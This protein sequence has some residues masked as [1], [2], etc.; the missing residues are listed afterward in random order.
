MQEKNKHT[1]DHDAF[2]QWAKQQL[3]NHQLPVDDEIWKG[4]EKK[5][6]PAPKRSV[7]FWYWLAG[8]VAAVVALMLLLRP[9]YHSS[10]RDINTQTI[11]SQ[12]GAN[13]QVVTSEQ[14]PVDISVRPQVVEKDHPATGVKSNNS[15]R[16]SN[17]NIFIARNSETVKTKQ[18]E[19]FGGMT[20]ENFVS[21]MQ[22]SGNEKEKKERTVSEEHP[23]TTKAGD[24]GKNKNDNS[25]ANVSKQQITSLPDLSDYPEE[26][27]V[28]TVKNKKNE[29]W[30]LAASLGAGSG[31]SSNGSGLFFETGG[32]MSDAALVNSTSVKTEYTADIKD[33]D[34]F[35]EVQHLPPVSFGLM[36]ELP[37]NRSWSLESG[38]VYTYLESRL[39]RTTNPTATGHLKLHYLGLPLYLKAKLWHDTS[40]SIY[41]SAGPMMEKGLKSIYS[42]DI[43]YTW[44]ITHTDVHSRIEGLQW[45]LNTGLGVNYKLQ[46]DLSVF[47][48]PKLTY[49]LD[50]NQP[51][52]A[53]TEQPL[54]IGLNGG[55]RIEL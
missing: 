7:P 12:K 29:H 14:N 36:A 18:T 8:G 46:K 15:A 17:K 27:A 32:L 19:E 23:V 55:L 48:E 1:N 2:S 3:E 22:T 10:G 41:L 50:N 54:V 6:A 24:E 35:N 53:R 13:K 39:K 47:F 45:S 42:Q 28:E 51:M 33:A 34:Y 44:S 4:I 37:L 25:K 38:F 11:V 52:S 9:F 31:I 20:A 30:L 49:Y 26:P 21:D 5:L 43:D 40:W 16:H